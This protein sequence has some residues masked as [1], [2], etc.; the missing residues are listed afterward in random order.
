MMSGAKTAIAAIIFAVGIGDIGQGAR[1]PL[2]PD[3]HNGFLTH[4]GQQVW[5][6]QN[7][8]ILRQVASA[9]KGGR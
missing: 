3:N 6:K 7:G 1:I 4:D 8:D 9:T 5:S 2:S